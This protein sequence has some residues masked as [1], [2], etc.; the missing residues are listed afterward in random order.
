MRPWLKL[1]ALALL[2]CTATAKAVTQQNTPPA[3][4]VDSRR[5]G[6]LD[7]SPATQA[8]QRDDTLNPAWLWLQDGERTF[9]TDCARCHSVAAMGGVA[10]RY[11]A[12]DA[13]LGKPLTLAGR[14]NQ[15]RLR[16]LKT[17][18][19]PIDSAELLGLET[20][21]AK[22]SRG[23]PIAP[24]AD[25]RLTPWREQGRTLFAQRFGQLGL[26]CAQCHDQHAGGRLAGSIIP[27]GH[28]NAY[29]LYRLEWQGLG[30][31][32]RRL[33]NCMTGVRAEP[34]AD[35]ADEWTALTLHLMQRAAGMAIETPGVRP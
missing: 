10:T 1:A 16:H 32:Q 6:L 26:S 3:A 14:I 22:Q 28:P 9:A 13:I 21:V 15:C 25:P 17:N 8:L 7:M 19:L 2:V 34:F 29:P 5:S 24:P 23:L 35:G 4:P 11:P 20:F 12:F 27:Q 30:S 18:A 33:R 31:L